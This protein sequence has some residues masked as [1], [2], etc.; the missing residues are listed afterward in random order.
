MPCTRALEP[1]GSAWCGRDAPRPRL[2]G[3][4]AAPDGRGCRRPRRPRHVGQLSPATRRARRPQCTWW[5]SSMGCGG[6]GAGALPRWPAG[7]PR[8]GGGPVWA[9]GSLWERRG[10]PQHPRH[11]A[12]C[13]CPARLQAWRH[14]SATV[15][16]NPGPPHRAV[17]PARPPTWRRCWSTWSARCRRWRAPASAWCWR[18]AVRGR[19][20]RG[21]G[22]RAR[23]GRRACP[24]RHST[25]W[26]AVRCVCWACRQHQP[27]AS[28]RPPA[29]CATPAAVNERGRTIQGID[30]CGDRLA[31]VRCWA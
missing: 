22:C 27:A 9:S 14:P 16:L 29:T 12:W 1:T 25:R 15:T 21:R 11:R 30:V 20:R 13:A 4:G 3:C 31:Q 6:E 23:A 2:S 28:L 17:P 8:S 26:P 10:T 5:S 7:R 18:T 19:G 24:G